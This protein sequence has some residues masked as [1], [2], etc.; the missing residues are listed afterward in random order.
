MIITEQNR[1]DPL[2]PRH[3]QTHKDIDTMRIHSFATLAYLGLYTGDV[4]GVRVQQNAHELDHLR[5]FDPDMV[6]QS[7]AQALS[8]SNLE[9]DTESKTS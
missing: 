1:A 6:D 9:V 8:S 5:A 4:Q 3:K 2:A 7:L